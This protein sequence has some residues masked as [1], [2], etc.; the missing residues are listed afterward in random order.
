VVSFL[1]RLN[2]HDYA[3]AVELGAMQRLKDVMTGGNEK[4]ASVA[5]RVVRDFDD[6]YCDVIIIIII[7]IIIIVNNNKLIM[8]IY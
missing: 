3:A 8:I 1:D 2:A 6:D 5:W 7:M 4:Q